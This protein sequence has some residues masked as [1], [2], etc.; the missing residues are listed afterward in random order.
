MRRIRRFLPPAA[1]IVF[2]LACGHLFARQASQEGLAVSPKSIEAPLLKVCLRLVD[3]SPFGGIMRVRLLPA[4]GDEI[5]GAPT[6]SDGETIFRSLQPGTYFLEAS[7]PGFVTVRREV[8]IDTGHG[9]QTLFVTMKP[10]QLPAHLS[11]TPTASPEA[12]PLPATLAEANLRSPAAP[13]R[14]AVAVS[15]IP[16]SLDDTVPSVDPAV[17]C[18]LPDILRMTGQRMTELVANLEKFSATEQVEHFK[19]NA[20]GLRGSPDVRSF[21]YV[22]L[23]SRNRW[24][25]FQLD[26]YRNGSVDPAQFP[27][28]IATVGLP[29]MALI[30]HPI[31]ASDFDFKCE[32]LGQSGGHPAWQ[33]H[34]AQRPDRPSRIRQYIIQKNSYPVPIKGRAWIDPGTD[35]VVRLESEL[36][37]PIPAIALTRERL[38]IEYGSVEF[39]SNGQRLWLPEVAELY[40]ERGTARYYRRHAFTN[41]K[42]F[43]VATNESIQP[44]EAYVFTNTSDRDIAGILTVYPVPGS[45][46][47]PVSLTFTIPAGKTIFKSVGP[48]KDVRI[49]IDSLGSATFSHNGPEGSVTV[50]AYLTNDSSV[51]VTPNADIP[52]DARAPL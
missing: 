34:F 6:G 14:S 46:L 22:V 7:A 23:I 4:E 26:E 44:K 5:S 10:A 24:G 36:I 39:H 16:P 51:D 8:R 21:D 18:P 43:T 27:A 45:A 38:S 35:Q 25:L 19:I 2:L 49:P 20:A 13:T 40:A 50:N 1:L 15:W 37:K 11:E 47:Q 17:A 42:L 9:L 30:F 31:L 28:G 41:F 48:G 3:D 52:T 32:G 12:K 33:I 29:A